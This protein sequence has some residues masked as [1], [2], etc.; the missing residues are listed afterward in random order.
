[1]NILF[2]KSNLDEKV[3]SN[4]L[5]FDFDTHTEFMELKCFIENMN[6]IKII[7]Y[8]YILIE[9]SESGKIT[10]EQIKIIQ[11]SKIAFLTNIIFLFEELN[12]TKLSQLISLKNIDFI[13]NNQ[14]KERLRDKIS[15]YEEHELDF[16]NYKMTLKGKLLRTLEH[17]W[18]QPLNFIATNFLNL[19]LK[20]ELGKL[21]NEDIQTANLKVEGALEQV[22]NSLSKL[23]KCFTQSEKKVHFSLKNLLEDVLKFIKPQMEKHG[24]LIEE[25]NFEDE[26]IYTYENEFSL[27]LLAILYIYVHFLI[28]IKAS[29]KKRLITILKQNDSLICLKIN[30]KLLFLELYE[31][32]LFEFI[33]IKKI[34]KRLGLSCKVEDEEDETKLILTIK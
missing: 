12:F 15:F 29:C 9:F 34:S 18:K 8:D 16:L 30:Q 6:K 31:E 21:E 32:F 22:S 33:I 20:S 5:I 26:E 7:F 17:Q 13:I 1:M 23:N 25:L 14:I 28:S 24:I 19:E 11:K 2:V 10:L 3:S 4:E 27:L